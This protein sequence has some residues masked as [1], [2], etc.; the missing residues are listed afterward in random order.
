M[1]G[2][3]DGG[4]EKND[5]ADIEFVRA[6]ET[7]NQDPEVAEIEKEF[8]GISDE[9]AE[10]GSDSEDSLIPRSVRRFARQEPASLIR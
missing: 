6:C 4:S 3:D 10:R 2:W 9:M 8:D 7:A 5:S 1:R